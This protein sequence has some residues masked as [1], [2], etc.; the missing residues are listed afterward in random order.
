VVAAVLG[1]SWL[2]R[3][4][5]PPR[6]EQRPVSLRPISARQWDQNRGRRPVE[7]RPE[8]QVVD[9]APGNLQRPKESKYL[10]ET[11]NSVEKQTRAREQTNKYRRAA[12]KNQAAPSP[13]SLASRFETLNE[14]E[15][16]KPRPGALLA[17][18]SPEP[19]SDTPAAT[20]GAAPNDELNDVEAGEGTYLNTREWK[21]AAFMNRVKQAVAAK[22]DPNGRLKAKEPRRQL[23]A[24][25]TTVLGVTLRPDG[26]LADVFVMKPC[27]I[28]Q[29]DL[30]AVAAFERAAPFLNPPPG[31]VEN[32]YIRF[33]FGFTLTQENGFM[34]LLSP[35][36]M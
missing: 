33:Q 10:A 27:G 18:P 2:T 34:P 15:G 30:E 3:T 29:L 22:W 1:I 25:R 14:L 17:Q 9:V 36:R 20:G 13:V 32:G 8:G 35:Q 6:V 12:P 16:A 23:Y 28:D 4:E 21:Y 5:R 26:T 24:P 11:D 19:P 7:P 31:L